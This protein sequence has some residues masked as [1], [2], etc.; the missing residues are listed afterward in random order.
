MRKTPGL[1]PVLGR[2]SPAPS[3]N[4]RR[5]AVNLVILRIDVRDLRVVRDGRSNEKS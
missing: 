5:P 1:N 2:I 3:S 4:S